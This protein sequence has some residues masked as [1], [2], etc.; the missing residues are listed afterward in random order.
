M[1]QGHDLGELVADVE[2]RDAAPV[3]IADE[4]EQAFHLR[5]G[6]AGGGLVHDHEPRLA[7]QRLG[8][9]EELFL[10]NDE[11]PY[12]GGGVDIQADAIEE[13]C[14]LLPHGPLVEERSA[15]LLA[16]QEDVVGNGEIIHQV[17]LLVDEHH[18]FRL[19]LALITEVAGCAVQ[20]HASA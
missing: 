20:E 16:S 18:A 1:R 9:L 8:D 19:G 13:R 3:E 10:R 5:G 2:D 11:L 14:R 7:P 15:T 6:E 4:L 12:P 17:E